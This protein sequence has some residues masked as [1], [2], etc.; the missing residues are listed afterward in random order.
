MSVDWVSYWGKSR[1][2]RPDSESL[3]P[4]IDSHC[5]EFAIKTQ[6]FI[7][8]ITVLASITGI[9]EFAAGV[10]VGVRSDEAFT[11]GLIF[12]CMVYFCP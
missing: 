6:I 12:S 11:C 5:L 7:F 1:F 10:V 3:R 4:V 2:R 9:M 8:Q